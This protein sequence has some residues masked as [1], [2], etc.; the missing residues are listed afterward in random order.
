MAMAKGSKAR[1]LGGIKETTYNSDPVTLN[2]VVLPIN[3]SAIRATQ[4]MN[5]A[6]TIRGRRDPSQPFLGNINVAGDVTVPMD[7]RAIGW[8]LYMLLGAPTTASV[9]GGYYKHTFKIGDTVDSWVLEQQY[10]DLTLYQK[11]NG[12]K[13]NAFKTTVGG[14]GELL[15]T[16][17]VIGGKETPGILSIDDHPILLPL[18]RFQ[19]FTATLKEGGASV[20]VAQTVDFTISNNLDESVYLIGM[21]GFRHSIPEGIM[22]I[23]GNI[24]VMFEN[25]DL[26]N[27]AVNGTESS[28]E[29]QFTTGSNVLK[30]IFNE[31]MYGRNAP[32]VEGPGGVWLTMPF[33]AYYSDDVGNSG[34]VVELTNDQSTYA[35]IQ[36][37]TTTSTT[38]TSSTSTTSSTT[39]T[40]G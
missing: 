30:F 39:T 13:V 24:K 20:A 19:Q 8:W 12:C 15:A 16:I 25:W 23:T 18:D 17:T 10:R 6:A 31:V 29:I 9:G 28:M 27:K 37:T 33:D 36:S 40:A 3:T 7:H 1:L 35:W 5:R 14:D 22:G 34:I 38:T 32:G 4:N 2:A 21:Q 11:F 26:Y